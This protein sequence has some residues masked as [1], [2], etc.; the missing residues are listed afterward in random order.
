METTNNKESQF[1][2]LKKLELDIEAHKKLISYCDKKSIMFLS[3]PF[4]QDSV[5]LL[6]DLGLTT[7][8]IPSGEITNL[9]YL[10]YIGKL[11]KKI[12]LSTGMANINEIKDALEILIQAG[13]KKKQYYSFACK[14]RVSNSY[15][16]CKFKSNG[17]NRKYI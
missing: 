1:S 10:R 2:M 11:N 7:F 4:D 15:G 8:K 12:I 13:T 3:S 17:N 6:D 5:R 14:H 16:R 9:P